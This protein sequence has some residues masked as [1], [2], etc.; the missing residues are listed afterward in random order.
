MANTPVV[1]E[2]PGWEVITLLV[3]VKAYPVIGQTSGESV[4]VAGVRLDTAEPEWVRLFPVGF[5]SLPPDQQFHKYDVV[6]LRA[7]RREGSDRRS[8]TYRPSLDTLVRGPSVDTDRGSWH[9]RWELV[10]ALAGETT[11][12]DLTRA[13]RER[14]QAAPSLGLI[15]PRDIKMDVAPNPEFRAGGPTDV[16]VDLFGTEREVLEKTPFLVTYRYRCAASEC[17]GGHKQSLIDWESGRLARRNLQNRSADEAIAL[18]RRRFF[19]ELCSPARDTYFFVGNQH[20]YPG[21]FLVLGV[22]WPP[23][24]S[25]PAPMFE[26]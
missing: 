4:C 19:D 18:H 13:A 8:E 25:R 6:R 12:C 11:T 22:F 26:F 15:K 10:G 20:Q 24:G 23:A 3:T 14:G 9:R 7:Q 17:S 16:D 1:P 2:R 5:R 21:S